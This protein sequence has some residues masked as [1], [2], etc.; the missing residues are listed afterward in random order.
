VGG[1]IVRG[2]AAIAAMS[3]LAPG[4]AQAESL[5]AQSKATVYR[6]STLASLLDLD[7]GTV[8]SDGTG[9]VVML[10]VDANARNCD[11]GMMCSAA[12]AF[13]TLYLTGSNATVQV[14]YD[15]V[16]Q[17]TGPGQPMDVS[18]LFPG[19]SGSYVTIT[20]NA[21]VIRFGASL[22]IN[23]NQVPGDYSG[24]FAVNVNYP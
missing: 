20:N 15:P 23:S 24:Q 19:G 6:P 4:T 18:L 21:A 14:T 11:P 10:D 8:V 13:A 17:L 7:F 1:K 22:T 9:G 16:T 12:Y 5:S 3:G 2:V